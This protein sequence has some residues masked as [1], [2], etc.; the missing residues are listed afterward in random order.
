MGW[1]VPREHIP[2]TAPVVPRA[3][4]PQTLPLPQR[5]FY[6]PAIA[7]NAGKS[8]VSKEVQPLRNLVPTCVTTL[9]TLFNPAK[10]IEVNALQPDKKQF[11]RLVTLSNPAK[12]NGSKVCNDLQLYRKHVPIFVTLRNPDKLIDSN[13]EHSDKKKSEIAVIANGALRSRLRKL[14]FTRN[15]YGIT[16]TTSACRNNCVTLG[17]STRLSLASV[18]SVSPNERRVRLLPPQVLC[19]VI[20]THIDDVRLTIKSLDVEF[21]W[22][23]VCFL[24]WCKT[25][26]LV[27]HP[28]V[29]AKSLR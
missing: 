11:P 16:V 20:H 5:H 15:L 17:S 1:D 13:D 2:T 27:I 26:P 8:Y 19:C 21:H 10:S 9:V 22:C 23:F 12:L 25:Q 14:V 29:W 7:L 18:R 4:N 28:C 3:P 6:L 24:L